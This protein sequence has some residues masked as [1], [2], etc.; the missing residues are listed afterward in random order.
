MYFDQ[1]PCDVVLGVPSQ[2]AY[3][4]VGILATT[5]IDSAIALE[6]TV[7]DLVRPMQMQ[8]QILGG[9]PGVHQYNPKRQHLDLNGLIEHFLHVRELGLSVAF[10]VKDTPVEDPIALCFGVDIQAVDDAD[11]LDQPMRI[12]AILQPHHFYFVRMVLVRDAVVKHKKCI[13]IGFND[14]FHLLPDYFRRHIIILQ[15]PVNSIMREVR[16]MIRKIGLSIVGLSR[17]KTLTIVSSG[18]FDTSFLGSF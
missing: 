14:A 2:V 9:V 6:G 16:V 8:H 7:E 4:P 12:T 17:H 10:R 18:W 13:R 5:V 3:R 1:L 11:S 15:I